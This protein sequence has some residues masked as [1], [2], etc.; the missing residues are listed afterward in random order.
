MNR[1]EEVPSDLGPPCSTKLNFTTISPG[2]SRDED[3]VMSQ[4]RNGTVTRQVKP[5]RYASVG[6]RQGL[7]RAC[8]DRRTA[9]PGSATT[10]PDAGSLGACPPGEGKDRLATVQTP[11]ARLHVTEMRTTCGR[12]WRHTSARATRDSAR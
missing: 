5:A 12:R 2:L 10:W 7:G 1:G 4:A 11:T 9:A 6:V 8:S 3:L